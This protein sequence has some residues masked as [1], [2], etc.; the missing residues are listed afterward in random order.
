MTAEKAMAPTALNYELIGPMSREIARLNFEGKIQTAVDQRNSQEA[1]PE[2]APTTEPEN[3]RLEP[4]DQVLHLEGWDAPVWFRPMRRSETSPTTMPALPQPPN[5][6]VLVAQLGD[7]QFLVT[8]LY[9]RIGFLP[10]G[11]A[12]KKPWQYLSVE[13]GAYENGKFKTSRILN[14]D[15]TDWGLIFR[16]SPEVLRVTLYLR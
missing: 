11:A 10:A 4:P 5:G 9:S 12:A 15:Q 6:R 14:G 13:E 2:T 1:K 7:N 3:P 8:G 16:E